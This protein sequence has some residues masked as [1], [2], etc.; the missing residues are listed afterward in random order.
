MTSRLA[1]PDSKRSTFTR[2]TA[3][4]IQAPAPRPSSGC[5]RA[6]TGAAP[7]PYRSRPLVSRMAST[8]A[9][10]GR[11]RRRPCTRPSPVRSICWSAPSPP[12]S[13]EGQG[14]GS[15]P[16][17]MQRA[18]RRC[19]TPNSI[20]ACPS[21][22]GPV[23]SSGPAPTAK[24]ARAL[25]THQ[26]RVKLGPVTSTTLSLRCAL[27]RSRRRSVRFR[28]LITTPRALI[29]AHSPIRHEQRPVRLI[30]IYVTALCQTRHSHSCQ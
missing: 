14:A 12:P 23:P 21:T 7:R 28:A 5:R 15:T 8:R 17:R 29:T 19:P 13:Q 27:P 22:T 11:G 30:A 3:F 1:R 18:T 2:T 26:A 24:K 4:L 6:P 10:M 16:A 25:H 20:P 9:P